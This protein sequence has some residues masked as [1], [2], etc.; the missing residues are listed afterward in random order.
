MV[1]KYLTYVV[2]CVVLLLAGQWVYKYYNPE[3]IVQKE[4]TPLKEK[5]DVP[6]HEIPIKRLVVLDKKKAV[7]KLPALPE[8]IK[9]DDNKQITATAVVEP[10]EGK[11]SVVAITDIEKGST[12][13]IAKREP[14]SFIS[15]VPKFEVGVSYTPIHSQELGEFVI[16]ASYHAVRIGKVKVEAIGNVDDKGKYRAGVRASMGW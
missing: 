7:K 12:E 1:N 14:I 8:S 10:Y 3:P 16:D 15:L 6:K 11:T 9:S 13:L 5:I 4:Y 2:I